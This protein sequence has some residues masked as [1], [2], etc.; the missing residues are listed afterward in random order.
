[1]SKQWLQIS[2]I[3]AGVLLAGTAALLSYADDRL[4]T[5]F[6]AIAGAAIALVSLEHLL[7]KKAKDTVRQQIYVST[8][9]VL[10][11]GLMTLIALVR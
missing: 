8:G 10:I 11:L 7:S 1:M 4:Y 6:A 2:V 9:T 5:A 3:W